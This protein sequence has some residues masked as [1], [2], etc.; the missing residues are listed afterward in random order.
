[1]DIVYVLIIGIVLCVLGILMRVG[2]LNFLIDRYEGFQKAIRRKKFSVEILYG[3]IFC[4]RGLLLD[5][6]DYWIYIS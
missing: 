2:W 4:F 6:S 1:M 5:C 3:L